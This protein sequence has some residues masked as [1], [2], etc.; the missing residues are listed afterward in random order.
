MPEQEPP[1]EAAAKYFKHPG[2]KLAAVFLQ[3]VLGPCLVAAVTSVTMYFMQIRNQVKDDVR[4]A[5]RV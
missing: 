1:Q 3:Y 2:W 5:G 4:S